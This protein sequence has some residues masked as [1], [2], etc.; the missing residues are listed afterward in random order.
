MVSM[1]E[2]LKMITDDKE[3][4]A[5]PEREFKAVIGVSPAAFVKLLPAFAQ[6]Q[7]ELGQKAAAS[8]APSPA[9]SWRWSETYLAHAGE[10]T[11]LH[12]ALPQRL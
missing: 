4:L 9:E 8:R 11:G 3:I 10:Q 2:H 7:A 6:S 12:L 1:L 5:L